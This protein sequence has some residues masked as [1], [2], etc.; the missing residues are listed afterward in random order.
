MLL[1][2]RCCWSSDVLLFRPFIFIWIMFMVCFLLECGVSIIVGGEHIK[3]DQFRLEDGSVLKGE[4]FAQCTQFLHL[5][6]CIAFW[7]LNMYLEQV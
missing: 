7:F 1:S 2:L 6:H 3:H 4:H 5:V